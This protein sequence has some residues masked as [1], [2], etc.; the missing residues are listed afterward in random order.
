MLCRVPTPGWP[1]PKGMEACYHSRHLFASLLTGQLNQRAARCVFLFPISLQDQLSWLIS[2]TLLGASC[3]Q[4][5][6][7]PRAKSVFGGTLFFQ[8][9]LW[10]C[11]WSWGLLVPFSLPGRH[12]EVLQICPSLHFVTLPLCSS[13]VTFIDII[14]TPLPLPIYL[15]PPFFLPFLGWSEG[16]YSW[17]LNPLALMCD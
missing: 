16:F 7:V 2:S 14:S 9:H 13:A 10:G 1:C 8:P 12:S 5:F 4:K 11:P 15:N 17:G 3:F 6:I